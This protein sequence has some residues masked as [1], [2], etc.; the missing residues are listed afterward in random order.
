MNSAE[1]AKRI[2]VDSHEIISGWQYRNLLHKCSY[3][4]IKFYFKKQ[5]IQ[6]QQ[7]TMAE[8]LRIMGVHCWGQGKVVAGAALKLDWHKFNHENYSILSTY[9]IQFFQGH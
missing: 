7:H 1:V 4:F 3:Y 2:D 5:L 6:G 8:N 9:L